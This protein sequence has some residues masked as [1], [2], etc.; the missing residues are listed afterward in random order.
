MEGLV[1]PRVELGVGQA[2]ALVVEYLDRYGFAGGR[3][4]RRSS[5]GT[6]RCEEIEV[7]GLTA[8]VSETVNSSQGFFADYLNGQGPLRKV[9]I[10]GAR[11]RVSPGRGPVR[12]GFSPSLFI[13]FPFLFL[14]SLENL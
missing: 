6:C 12:A 1:S 7:Q 14:P 10:T 8:I 13:I 9:D 5:S 4:H 2:R 3:A 11:G